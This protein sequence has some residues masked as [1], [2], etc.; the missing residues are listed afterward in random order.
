MRATPLSIPDVIRIEPDVF[1]DARGFFMETWNQRVFAEA[2]ISADFVQDNIS[3]SAQG[4]LRG[5]HFQ[6][7]QP[8]GK[9]VRVLA[10]EVFDLVVDLR[11]SSPTFGQWVGESLSDE[12]RNALW[13]PPGFAHGFYV[14]RGPADFSYKCTDFY[15]PQ[16]ERTLQWDDPELGIAWPLV[17]G[18]PP[19]LSDKDRA[20]TP[21]SRI[22]TYP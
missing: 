16:H 9:L 12:N 17:D 11:R 20:G 19:I 18:A 2:G 5:L 4:I 13:V 15:A 8:Q 14:T 21:L 6:I 3:R 22:E 10:G 7:R 1:G